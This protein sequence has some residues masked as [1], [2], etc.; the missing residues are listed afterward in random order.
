MDIYIPDGYVFQKTIEELPGVHPSVVLVYRPA[1]AIE[2]NRMIAT[3]DPIALTTLENEIIEKYVVTVNGVKLEPKKPLRL[4]L[5]VKFCDLI[6][7]YA[8]SDEERADLGN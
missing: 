3:R 5:R 2:R 6:L 7:Q 4:S 1:P 8:G